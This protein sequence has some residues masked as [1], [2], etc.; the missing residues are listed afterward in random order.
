MTTTHFIYNMAPQWKILGVI[1]VSLVN[2]TAH[3]CFQVSSDLLAPAPQLQQCFHYLSK[4]LHLQRM[5]D[6]TEHKYTANPSALSKFPGFSPI[7]LTSCFRG[8]DNLP[9]LRICIQEG[10]LC[11]MCFPTL[12]LYYSHTEAMTHGKGMFYFNYLPSN[13]FSNLTT[14]FFLH[15]TGK[16][17]ILWAV[18]GCH[19]TV[20]CQLL[21]SV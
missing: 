11:W 20:Q 2:P 6:S 21:V 3:Y 13:I 5:G 12:L 16:L 15:Y 19:S 9:T 14:L 4:Y 18:K 8:F 1:P 7:Q 10:F 17:I